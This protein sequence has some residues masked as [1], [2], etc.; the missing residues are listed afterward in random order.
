MVRWLIGEQ[1]GL[2]S[3]T[4]GFGNHQN[5]AFH[6]AAVPVASVRYMKHCTCILEAS[7]RF[8]GTG[9]PNP[10]QITECPELA[11]DSKSQ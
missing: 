10:S 11:G 6:F 5:F 8:V 4:F 2:L 3:F 9:I 7:A 1:L